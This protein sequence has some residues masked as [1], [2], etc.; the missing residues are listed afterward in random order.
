MTWM[1]HRTGLDESPAKVIAR[2]SGGYPERQLGKDIPA[3]EDKMRRSTS[4]S[5]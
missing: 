5:G 1:L 3:S 2:K 4:R